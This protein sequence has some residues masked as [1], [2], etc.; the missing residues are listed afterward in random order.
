[1]AEQYFT[2]LTITQA[3]YAKNGLNKGEYENCV[4]S[5]IDLSGAD[6]S[7][8]HFIDCR[9]EH[10][11]LS[12]AKLHKT[13]VRDVVFNDCKMSGLV[14]SD[15]DGFLFSAQFIQCQLPYASFQ[16]MK[17]KQHVFQDCQLQDADFTQADCSGAKFTGT[18]LSRTIFHQTNLEGADFSTAVHFS[19]DP[20]QN[21]L[22]KAIFSASNL[23]GLLDKYQ[24]KI[25]RG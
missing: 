12:N 21:R 16:Q 6:L 3:D 9:F 20:E 8:I 7:G 11:Q 15:C 4:F 10:Y 18:D 17:L 2:D 13:V 24:L 25:L 23:T 14:F 22:K 19:I 1:M 5:K